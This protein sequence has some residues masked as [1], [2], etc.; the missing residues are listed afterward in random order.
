MA[1]SL[2][3]GGS[4][5]A[6]ST[7]VNVDEMTRQKKVSGQLLVTLDQPALSFPELAS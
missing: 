6:P 3:C 5:K 2:R 1:A 4:T 7:G